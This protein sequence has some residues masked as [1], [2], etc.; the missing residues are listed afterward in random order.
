[1]SLI[2][3]TQFIAAAG[4]IV[5]A[6]VG[7]VIKPVPRKSKLT[8]YVGEFAKYALVHVIT[9]ATA[10][11]VLEVELL[12]DHG[13]STLVFSPPEKITGSDAAEMLL[14][15]C[16]SSGNWDK[17]KINGKKFKKCELVKHV[18]KDSEHWGHRLLAAVNH[19]SG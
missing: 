11:Y 14:T 17:T 8:K 12:N 16:L 19:N 3:L 5:N 18:N 10:N 13:I 9:P 6:K 7:C 2:R 4:E 1:M 15:D